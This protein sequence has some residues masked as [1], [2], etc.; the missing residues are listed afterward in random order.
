M[1]HSISRSIRNEINGSTMNQTNQRIK[2]WIVI[3]ICL[4]ALVIIITLQ[5]SLTIQTNFLRK[6]EHILVDYVRLMNFT[7]EEL[8]TMISTIDSKSTTSETLMSDE[9]NELLHHF[10]LTNI[11]RHF[12]PQARLLGKFAICSI[13]KISLS[14]S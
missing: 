7:E 6:N 14:L 12:D 8:I 4:I 13:S 3:V 9:I 5:S 11:L 10:N 2:Q 1:L